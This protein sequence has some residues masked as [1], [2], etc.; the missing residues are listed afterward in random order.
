[1]HQPIIF[2]K[3]SLT[4]ALKQ[5]NQNVDTDQQ[6]LQGLL[7]FQ[8]IVLRRLNLL[9]GTEIACYYSVLGIVIIQSSQIIYAIPYAL[10]YLQKNRKKTE[11]NKKQIN[12]KKSSLIQKKYEKIKINQIKKQTNKIKQINKYQLIK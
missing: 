7:Y 4:Q 1:M 12:F 3:T 9:I 11:E 6:T 2:Y 10:F 8:Q 5:N